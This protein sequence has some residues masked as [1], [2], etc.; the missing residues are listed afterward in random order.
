MNPK[1]VVAEFPHTSLKEGPLNR[2]SKSL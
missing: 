2:D 1:H